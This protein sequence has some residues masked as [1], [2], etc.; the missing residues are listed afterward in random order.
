MNRK[1]LF[2]VA[3]MIT[4]L[5]SLPWTAS[6]I[7]GS[8]WTV[9]PSD[10]LDSTNHNV[11]STNYILQG[12]LDSMA[13][14]TTSTNYIVDTGD[15]MRWYCGDGFID[16]DES[17]DGDNNLGGATCVSQGFASGTLTC[18]SAC[19]YVTSACVSGGGGGG[20]GGGGASVSS[21][22][23]APAV[24]SSVPSDFVYTS[25]LLVSGTKGTDATSVKVNTSTTGVTY[26]T[27]T[28]WNVTVS[29]AYGLNTFNL[30]A[31]NTSG[32]SPTTVFDVYRRLIGDIT[33]DN[34]V[35]DYDLSRL[36]K[37]WST[38]DRNGDFNEDLTV[39]DY[40]FSMLVARWGTSV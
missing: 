28:T 8:T 29:L 1:Q 37:L 3:L 33:Q 11:S 9:D 23:S 13:A 30:I 34:T 14:R 24:N 17:C 27:T 26:P 12:S 39:N 22:P 5:V 20:G 21:K 40:D 4:A 16:P 7:S 35:N 38:T 18:S 10:G 36:V 32:D 15:A 25:S 6:A 31:S 2:P 19:A